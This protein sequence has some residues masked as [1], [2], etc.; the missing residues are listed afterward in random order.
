[1]IWAYTNLARLQPDNYEI[2]NEIGRLQY[3]RGR[4]DESIE[5]FRRSLEVEPGVQN[6]PTYVTLADMY[7]AA[8]RLDSTEAVL[9]KALSFDEG[10]VRLRRFLV[11]MYFAEERYDDA[12]PHLQTIVELEPNNLET[13]RHLATLYMALDSSDQAQ[14]I[15]QEIVASGSPEFG[16]Y[17]ALGQIAGRGENWREAARQFKRATGE[18]P[19]IADGWLALGQSYRQIDEG[20]SEVATYLE[21]VDHMR[22]EEAAIQLYFAAG[23]AYER[24][25]QVDSAISVFEMILEHDPNNDQVLNYLGYTLADRGIRLDYADELIER[26]IAIQPNNAAYLDSYGWVKFRLGDH[27]AAVEYLARAAALDNDPEILHHLGDAYWAL[28]E[29]EQARRAWR[30]VLEVEPDNKTIQEKLDR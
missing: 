2:F 3:S 20:H 18:N 25:D 13:Q 28:G 12:L 14:A 6:Y 30:Q 27:E 21:G 16:D 15:L 10:N 29:H 17:F 22:N 19:A 5:A 26:A 1:M 9:L 24:Q 23:A 7:R 11:G 8:G 4:T